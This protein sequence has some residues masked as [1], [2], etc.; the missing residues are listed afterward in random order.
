MHAGL[1]VNSNIRRILQF[2]SPCPRQRCRAPNVDAEGPL[3]KT[4]ETGKDNKPVHQKVYNRIASLDNATAANKNRPVAQLQNA[5]KSINTP[6]NVDPGACVVYWMRME[7]LHSTSS[8]IDIFS[9]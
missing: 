6:D 1:L 5:L 2:L 8:S 4:P 7:D 9:F 3:S